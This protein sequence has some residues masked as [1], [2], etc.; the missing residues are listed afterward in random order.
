[1]AGEDI[2]ECEL[3]DYEG[4]FEDCLNIA[5][6]GIPDHDEDK[7]DNDKE[8]NNVMTLKKKDEIVVEVKQ[9]R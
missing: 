1:M 3:G 5:L 9:H 8:Q 7:L 4:D 6:S 2:D